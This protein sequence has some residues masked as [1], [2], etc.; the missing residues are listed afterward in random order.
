MTKPEGRINDEARMTN[1]QKK[2]HA[3]EV[4]LG[5]I[6]RHISENY[7]GKFIQRLIITWS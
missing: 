3:K 2:V 5:K 1:D 6:W 7:E 4:Y